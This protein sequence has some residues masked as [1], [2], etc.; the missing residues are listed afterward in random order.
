M[1]TLSLPYRFNTFAQTMFQFKQY[2]NLDRTYNAYT[3]VGFRLFRTR[4]NHGLTFPNRNIAAKVLDPL[5]AHGT[6]TTCVMRRDT[7]FSMRGLAGYENS[8]IY[9]YLKHSYLNFTRCITNCN[10]LVY[11]YIGTFIQTVHSKLQTFF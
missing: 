10:L 7:C 4:H 9:K 11:G 6:K 1:S 5:P 8:L 3:E 2:Q